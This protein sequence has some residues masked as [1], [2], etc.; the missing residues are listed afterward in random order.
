MKNTASTIEVDAVSKVYGTGDVAVRALDNITLHASVGEVVALMGPSGSGKTTLLMICGGLLHPTSGVVRVEGTETT[1]LSQKDLA[2]FRL[3]NVGFVF[4]DFNLLSALTALEN[5]EVALNLAGVNP[6]ESKRRAS[7]LLVS[8]G[9]EKRLNFLPKN[10]SGGEKQR[11][12][13]ARAL[14]NDP[15]VILA[16]EPTG[17]LDSRMGGEVARLLHVLAKEQGRAVVIATHDP[18]IQ[19]YADRIITLED[20]RILSG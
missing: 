8:L 12:A 19:P 6:P 18:R 16:D 15:R 10:L 7:N 9:L 17:N 14:T 11:V 3:G 13:V 4:Q 5:V 20:G 1:K 2:V